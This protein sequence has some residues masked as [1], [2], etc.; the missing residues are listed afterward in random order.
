MK[1]ILDKIYD[2]GDLKG[3]YIILG[4]IYYSYTQLEIA[5]M[6]SLHFHKQKD[7]THTSHPNY[8]LLDRGA[9][10]SQVQIDQIRS[11]QS[12]IYQSATFD[13]R[14]FVIIKDKLN[15]NA[16]NSC[17]K[18]LEDIPSDTYI[19]YLLESLYGVPSTVVSRGHKIFVH[20]NFKTKM[21][22]YP[23]GAPYKEQIEY[24]KTKDCSIKDLQEE[25][26]LHMSKTCMEQLNKN[27]RK[28]IEEIIKNFEFIKK[29]A[30]NDLHI[31]HDPIQVFNIIYFLLKRIVRSI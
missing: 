5:I 2:K 20:R 7:K 27:N 11:L 3:F 1:Q 6:Q 29:N 31:E 21:H 22:D 14:K 16:H 4:D 26:M 28:A 17:L 10:K 8:F 19:F 13:G 18:L 24:F 12:F 30:Y 9:S 25:V 15:I 23:F